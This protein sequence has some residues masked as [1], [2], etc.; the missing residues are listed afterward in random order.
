MR[1]HELILG[2]IQP[3]PKQFTPSYSFVEGRYHYKVD[4]VQGLVQRVPLTSDDTQGSA[5]FAIAPSE[6]Q[7][8]SGGSKR[9]VGNLELPTQSS[10]LKAREALNLKLNFKL[11]KLRLPVL[12]L[13]KLPRPKL[14]LTLTK[15]SFRVIASACTIAFVAGGVLVAYPLYPA[16]QYEISKT[17][18]APANQVAAAPNEPIAESNVLKIPKIG[19]ETPI[20]EAPTLKILDTKEGVWHQ[21]GSLTNNFVLAGHRWRYLPP[22]TST[23]Y[24]LDKLEQG[25]TIIIDWFKHRYI[26]VVTE[27]KVVSQEEDELLAPTGS[28]QLTLYTCNDRKEKERVVVIATP[29]Q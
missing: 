7:R 28:R 2:A 26:Y 25:D 13:P 29:L 4:A 16:V 1:E 14:D 10:K 6:S 5:Y 21:R 27:K 18:G 12:T 22:N 19:L 8:E 11:P 15:A 23:F 20:L 3:A 9:G 17:V 24:N